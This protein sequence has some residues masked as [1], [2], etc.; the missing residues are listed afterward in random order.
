MHAVN[1]EGKVVFYEEHSIVVPKN[2]IE[3]AESLENWEAA[4]T[5][6]ERQLIS[7]ASGLLTCMIVSGELRLIASNMNSTSNSFRNI[8][9]F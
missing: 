7:N 6:R 3:L 2:M 5:K 8:K 1:A 4:S 9:L